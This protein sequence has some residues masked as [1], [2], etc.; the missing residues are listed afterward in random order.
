MKFKLIGLF[1]KWL[2]M[3]TFRGCFE[4]A[5]DWRKMLRRE[6]GLAIILFVLATALSF[7]A[8][9]LISAYLFAERETI[10]SIMRV[11]LGTVVFTFLYN[12]FKVLWENFINE[13]AR[14][15]EILRDSK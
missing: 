9:G 4:A 10:T 15:F 7:V 12:T 1:A 14:L 6:T 5:Q 13:R 2:F 3:N 11:Y 8:V